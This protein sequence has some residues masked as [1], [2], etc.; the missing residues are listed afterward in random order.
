MPGFFKIMVALFLYITLM[1]VTIIRTVFNLDLIRLSKY[2]KGFNIQT[3][4]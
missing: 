2:E 4:I 3:F 1:K